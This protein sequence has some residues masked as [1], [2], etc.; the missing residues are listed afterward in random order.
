M[1]PPVSVPVAKET[2]PAPTRAADPPEEP[3][4]LLSYPKDLNMAK[5][6]V[7]VCRTHCKLVATRF[8]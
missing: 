4:G 2:C 3:P 1:D 8:A 7:L 5:G 6:T